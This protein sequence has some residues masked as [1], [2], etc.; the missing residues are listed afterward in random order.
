MRISRSLAW[1]VFVFEAGKLPELWTGYA[2]GKYDDVFELQGPRLSI[3]TSHTIR[4]L[5]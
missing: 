2:G 3:E 5:R 4:Y 1:F